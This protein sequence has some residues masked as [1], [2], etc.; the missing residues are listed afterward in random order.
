MMQVV[1]CVCS[2][3]SHD[4]ACSSFEVHNELLFHRDELLGSGTPSL[5]DSSFLPSLIIYMNLNKLYLCISYLHMSLLP[6]IAWE[7]RPL[8][9]LLACFLTLLERVHCPPRVIRCC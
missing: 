7:M 3:A 5:T 4:Y 6:W 1:S 8:V 2:S 9:S